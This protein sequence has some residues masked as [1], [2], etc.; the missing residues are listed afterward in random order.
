MQSSGTMACAKHFPG[1]GDTSRDSHKTLPTI[2]FDKTRIEDVEL[3]PYKNL[4]SNGLSSIMIAH[5]N[6][7]AFDNNSKQPS[8][9]SGEIITNILKKK[10]NFK[11][12]IFTDALDMKG[13]SNY[14]P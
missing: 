10:L 14:A 2:S 6:V 3:F 5:L 1:H 4:I 13:V 11:G 8:S 12:L 7:P 9:L